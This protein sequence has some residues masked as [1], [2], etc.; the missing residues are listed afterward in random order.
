MTRLSAL[1]L[2]LSPALNA[3]AAEPPPVIRVELSENGKPRWTLDAERAPLAQVLTEVGAKS[4][5][6]IHFSVLPQETVTATCAGD[7][8]EHIVHCLLGADVDLVVR[9]AAPKPVSNGTKAQGAQELWIL[10]SSYAKDRAGSRATADCGVA[11]ETVDAK[12]MAKAENTSKLLGTAASS[13]DASARANALSRLITEAHSGDPEVKAGLERALSD[14]SGDVRAQ[15]VYGLARRE[16]PQMAPVLQDAL[17]DRDPSVRLMAVD[18]AWNDENGTALLREALLDAD[19]T[20]REAAA[21]KL[22]ERGEAAT[23][24]H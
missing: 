13:R 12:A 5:M 11:V 16:G 21:M 4:G 9:T 19:E 6:K 7:S 14:Q 10:G 22:D 1:C 20:V 23:D 17:R 18:S 15:A 24:Q 2:M 8:V 3:F